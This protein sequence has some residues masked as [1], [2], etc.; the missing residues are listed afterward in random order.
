MTN[1]R[2]Y[3]VINLN[4]TRRHSRIFKMHSTAVSFV[5]KFKELICQDE[6]TID[7]EEPMDTSD[8]ESLCG[9]R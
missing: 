9:Q 3:P 7:E 1:L 5:T 2:F 8:I 6:L 4:G